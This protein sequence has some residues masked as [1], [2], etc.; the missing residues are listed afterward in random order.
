MSIITRAPWP[1]R[2][3]H[4]YPSPAVRRGRAC[5]PWARKRTTH[6][7]ACNALWAVV[8]MGWT[9][10]AAANVL[11]IY[12]GTVSRIVRGLKFPDAYSIPIPGFGG[13]S[14]GGPSALRG[15]IPRR[16]GELPL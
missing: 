11:G 6:M 13:E 1:R 3:R 16:Q 14:S 4:P 15:H 10:T 9:Q 12:Q 2:R 8:V 7:H 5:Q